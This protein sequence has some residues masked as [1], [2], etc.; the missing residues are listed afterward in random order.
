MDIKKDLIPVLDANNIGWTEIVCPR[1]K[2]LNLVIRHDSQM[3]N[4][5]LL[6]TDDEIMSIEILSDQ[7]VD[8]MH[9]YSV[10]TLMAPWLKRGRSYYWWVN[11]EGYYY[12]RTGERG[13]LADVNKIP[14]IITK[15]MDR[16]SA[17]DPFIYA[18]A[19]GKLSSVQVLL[20]LQ[21]R[22]LVM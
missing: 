16:F 13:R 8:P 6:Y 5:L 4:A 9:Y 11:D 22:N 20:E 10:I 21:G 18:L 17:M 7:A 3:W 2:G 19:H 15:M 12:L 14:E 1:G